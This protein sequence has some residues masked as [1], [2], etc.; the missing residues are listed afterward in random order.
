LRKC[1]WTAE[2]PMFKVCALGG[3]PGGTWQIVHLLGS[4]APTKSGVAEGVGL[5]PFT[6]Q[7]AKVNKT[8]ARTARIDEP[9]RRNNCVPFETISKFFIKPFC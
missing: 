4:L 1:A 6:V 9:I 2:Q 7:N 3:L 5:A 8:Q